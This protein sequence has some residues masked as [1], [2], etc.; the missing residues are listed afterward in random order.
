MHI[1]L[2]PTCFFI[3]KVILNAFIAICIRSCKVEWTD[4][5][6]NQE[7]WLGPSKD[8]LKV[9][10]FKGPFTRGLGHADCKNYILQ[11]I[12]TKLTETE[13][14]GDDSFIPNAYLNL[15]LLPKKYFRKLQISNYCTGRRKCF[16]APKNILFL[17]RYSNINYILMLYEDVSLQL[18]VSRVH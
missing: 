2:A 8:S 5:R 10:I 18:F 3:I 7:N 17:F 11:K 1:R 4:T 6:Q 16:G 9:E 13:L 15:F 14:N 12:I